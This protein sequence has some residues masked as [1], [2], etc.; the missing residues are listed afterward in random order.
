[1]PR[2][3]KSVAAALLADHHRDR[4]LK[5]SKD[6]RAAASSKAESV[7][8]PKSFVKVRS[9]QI[10]DAQAASD[11]IISFYVNS[12]LHAP[13]QLRTIGNRRSTFRRRSRSTPVLSAAILAW[14]SFPPR[15]QGVR[16]TAFAIDEVSGEV[17]PCDARCGRDKLPTLHTLAPPLR[18]R[19]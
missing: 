17:G 8:L 11:R 3:L 1:M 10:R 9:H 4:D 2:R 15:R 7:Y 16:L 12:C 18:A 14:T 19:L 13:R 5:E 6:C